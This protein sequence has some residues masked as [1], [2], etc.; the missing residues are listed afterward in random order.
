MATALLSEYIFLCLS[1]VKPSYVLGARKKSQT[2][3]HRIDYIQLLKGKREMCPDM[4]SV[5][6]VVLA[7]N[8]IAEEYVSEESLDCR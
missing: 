3:I 8:K 5:H 1:L 4:E 6:D 2:F 7:E